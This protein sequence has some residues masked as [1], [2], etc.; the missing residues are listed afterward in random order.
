[1][2]TYKMAKVEW[3]DIS[4]YSAWR[5]REDM[6]KCRP[7]NCVSVGTLVKVTRGNVGLSLS[8]SENGD[9]SGATV[10]PKKNIRNMKVIGSYRI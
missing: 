5:D 2:R 7:L 8:I 10:I 1:M 9:G 6:A 4:G 3:E